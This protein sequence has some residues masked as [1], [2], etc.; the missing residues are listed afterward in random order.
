M[1]IKLVLDENCPLAD[2]WAMVLSNISRE[3]SYA[4]KVVDYLTFEDELLNKL[5][6]SFS[7]ANYNKK[8]CN[9]N[10]LGKCRANYKHVKVL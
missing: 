6:S 3:S 5:V 9:L 2:A 4:E 10:Y 8:K 7:I 1:S